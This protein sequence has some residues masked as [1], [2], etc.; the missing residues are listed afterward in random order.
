MPDAFNPSPAPHQAWRIDLFQNHPEV[1]PRLVPF[2]TP[3]FYG[4][5]DDQTI[6][7][8]VLISASLGTPHSSLVLTLT[9]TLAP[10]PTLTPT[11][12]PTLTN[13]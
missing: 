6:F 7:N 2:A 11:L 1:V 3:P 10:S 8:D 13:L 9:L 4:N 12:S 5:S